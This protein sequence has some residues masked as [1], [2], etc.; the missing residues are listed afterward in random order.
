[1]QKNTFPRLNL[2][3]LIKP[4][5]SELTQQIENTP[6]TYINAENGKKVAVGNIVVCEGKNF[7]ELCINWSNNIIHILLLSAY[8][9]HEYYDKY[10]NEVINQKKV[11]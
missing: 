11:D 7:Q 3:D 4:K 5:E 1:M 9:C 6:F 2:K 10:F 8:L